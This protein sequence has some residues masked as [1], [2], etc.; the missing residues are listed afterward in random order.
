VPL[1]NDPIDLLLDTDGDIVVSGGDVVFA[2]GIEAVVQRLRRRLNLFR[3]EWFLDLDEGVPWVATDLVSES[4]AILGG[5]YSELKARTALRTAI[6]SSPGV[7]ELTALDV[8][9]VSQTRT[10]VVSFRVRTEFGDTDT[11]TLEIG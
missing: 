3:G 8:S 6:L 10:L 4:E 11:Q 1:V 2:T 7:V 9:F 5:K